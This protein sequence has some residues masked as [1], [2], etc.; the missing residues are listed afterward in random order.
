VTIEADDFTARLMSD[1]DPDLLEFIKTRVNSFIK[2]D[3][4]RFFHENPHTTDTA[5]NIARYSGRNPAAVEPE[6]EELAA[7]GIMR[8]QLVGGIPVYSLTDD[9]ATRDL[10]RQFVQACEDRHFRVKA[11]YHII[12]HMH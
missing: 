10:I 8:K 7:S 2:W 5:E 6:L 4:V 1:M 9:E 11:V 3:L 12:R